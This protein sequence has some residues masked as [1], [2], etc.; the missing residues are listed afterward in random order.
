M[1]HRS[2]YKVPLFL[3]DF[4]ET[5]IFLTN[6]LNTLDIKIIA[7]GAKLFRA[8]RQADRY[9]EANSSFSQFCIT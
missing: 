7:I 3:S 6:F 1:L 2:S 8:D 9:G 4:N 5:L